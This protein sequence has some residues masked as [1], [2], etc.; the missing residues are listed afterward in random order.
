MAHFARIEDG[1]VREV[2][3]VNN[4]AIGGGN[5]PESEPLGQSFLQSIGL[6]GTWKQ[7]SYNGNFRNCYPGQGYAYDEVLDQFIPP[8]IPE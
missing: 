5:F 3:V 7:C 8:V 4:D 6:A 1:I 2:I